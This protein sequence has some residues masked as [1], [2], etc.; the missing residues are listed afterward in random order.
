MHEYRSTVNS[1]IQSL[2]QKYKPRVFVVDTA[3]ALPNGAH[4]TLSGTVAA[5]WD[6]DGLHLTESGSAKLAQTV[7][8]TYTTITA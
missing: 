3:S 5:Y 1:G 8:E 4:G 6:V 2:G 7:F